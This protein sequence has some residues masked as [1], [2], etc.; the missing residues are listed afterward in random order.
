M[1][2]WTK[3]VNFFNP[4]I[5]WFRAF[6]KELF[7]AVMEVLIAELVKIAKEVVEE[8][9]KKDLSSEDKRKAAFNS[10]KEIALNKGI[11]I[12]DHL[13]NLAIELAYAHFRKLTKNN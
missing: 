3:I 10:I 13:I 7:D 8:L 9:A 6:I 4:A 5:R 2:L 11:D 12:K 1:S